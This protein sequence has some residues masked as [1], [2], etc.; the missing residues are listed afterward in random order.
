LL[1]VSDAARAIP[2]VGRAR[3]EHLERLGVVS[4]DDLSDCSRA[5]RTGALTPIATLVAGAAAS[6]S[7]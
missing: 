4:V 7:A 5:A 3:A 1:T 6:F 2:G